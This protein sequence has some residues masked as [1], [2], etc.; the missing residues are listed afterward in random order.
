MSHV[1]IAIIQGHLTR[2]PETKDVNETTVCRFTLASNRKFKDKEEV[3]FIT[4]HAWGALAKTCTDFLEK[5]RGV[6]VTGRL[7]FDMWEADGEKRSRHSIVAQ[8]VTFIPKAAK[9][10]EPY[11]NRDAYKPLEKDNFND[12]VDIDDSLPF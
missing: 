10:D 6:I 5:G 1:N 9:R 4:V 3:C 2:D 8:E 11:E 7:K 12:T